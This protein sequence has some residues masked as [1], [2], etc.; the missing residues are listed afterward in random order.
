M[1]YQVTN[2]RRA[3]AG[4]VVALSL[5]LAAR[6]QGQ[7]PDSLAKAGTAPSWAAIDRILGREGKDQPGGVRRYSFPRG[8]L[9]VVCGGVA[10]KPAFALGSWVAFEGGSK[11]TMAMGDLVLQEREIS[12]VLTKLQ[13][14]GVQ[15]TALHNHLLNESPH[16]MYLHIEVRGQAA[17]I[18]D[19]IHTA[20]TLTATPLAKPSAAP[21]SGAFPLDTARI[22]ATLGYGGNVNA[23]VYQVSVPRGEAIRADGMDVQRSMGVATAINFQPTEAGKAAITGDFVLTANA[24]GLVIQALRSGGIEVTA[25]HSHMLSEEP[26]LFFLHYWADAD[27]VALARA[28]RGALDRMNVKRATS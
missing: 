5:T 18:A 25:V 27:A 4:L 2:A 23:G 21:P 7:R 15:P 12:P 9:K 17:R 20:L 28:L 3:S 13:Q 24:V 11:D 22:K 19:A 6:V 8:D 10:L 26:W 14:L 1:Y 16:V